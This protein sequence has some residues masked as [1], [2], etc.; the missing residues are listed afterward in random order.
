MQDD[1]PALLPRLRGHI[2]ETIRLAVPVVI[3]RAGVMVMAAVDTAMLG[4]TEVEQLAFYGISIAPFVVIIVAGIGLMVGTVVSTS[5]AMG[6]GAYEECGAI[7]RRSLPYALL[8]GFGGLAIC[9]AGEWFFGL[10]GQAPAIAEGGGR[11][12]AILGYGMPGTLLYSAA[13]FFL[14]GIR[15][16]VPAMFVM[17]AANLL[18]VLLNW[19]LIFGHGGFPAMG[20]E[21]AAISTATVRLGMA[22][23]LL[24]YVWWMPDRHRYAVRGTPGRHWWRD[25]AQQRRYGY[26]TGTSYVIEE[27]ALSSI[28]FLAGMLGALPLAAY[29]IQSVAFAFVYMAGL[30]FGSATGVR[31][32]IAHGAGDF[33]NRAMAGWIGLGLVTAML[34]GAGLLFLLQPDWVTAVFTNDPALVV[35]AAPLIAISA[36]GVMTDGAQVVMSSALRGAAEAWSPPVIQAAAYYLVMLPVAWLLAFHMGMGASGLVWAIVAASTVSAVLLILRF[37]AVTRRKIQ[38]APA[39]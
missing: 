2:A 24:A 27:S 20:A 5:H 3:T 32:G 23:M 34:G 11:V 36:L 10:T 7:F 38:P 1:P 26:A 18:N 13:S 39:T 21:G 16:P 17:I 8:I 28:S 37:R 9:Q 31:V 35:A 22:A 14:E 29:T 19:L 12:I 25:G 6:R 4:R 15:R 30:G 33:G